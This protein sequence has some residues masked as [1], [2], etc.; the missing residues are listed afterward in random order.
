MRIPPN[1]TA[2]IYLEHLKI[3]VANAPMSESSHQMCAFQ[4]FRL[5]EKNASL[6]KWIHS[7]PNGGL[8]SAGTAGKM[9]GEGQKAGVPDVFW[10]IP[11]AGCHGLRVEL[12]VPRF[13]GVPGMSRTVP[14]GS[15]TPEQDAWIEHYM[16]CGYHA[17]V[18]Y[19]CLELIECV[20]A[21][22]QGDLWI[23]GARG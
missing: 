15:T 16:R 6:F 23:K 1:I 19:G 7:I 21:Y 12:K 13:A 8:R 22:Y 9:R 3:K 17:V 14:A 20:E 4:Y 10:D 18:A 5:R 2:G 11:R